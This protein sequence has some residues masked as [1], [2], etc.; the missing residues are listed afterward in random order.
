M[1]KSLLVLNECV[2]EQCVSRPTMS[3]LSSLTAPSTK[4]SVLII[5][6]RAPLRPRHNLE[7]RGEREKS[8]ALGSIALD[9]DG[10]PKQKKYQNRKHPI[11]FPMSPK[12]QRCG[13]VGAGNRARKQ[14]QTIHVFLETSLPKPLH[15]GLVRVR[16][17]FHLHQG[18]E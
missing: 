10:P 3:S 17:T 7:E 18:C 15:F 11:G 14:P 16:I 6:P 9:K 1:I 8:E 12:E 4:D 5:N 2:S 13:W